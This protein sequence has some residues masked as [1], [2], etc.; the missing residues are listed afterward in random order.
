[1]LQLGLLIF[2]LGLA[3]N[4]EANLGLQPWGLF[5][6]GLIRFIP[7]TYG[8][9]TI[10]IG[11]VM[12][13]VSW[14]ARVPPGFGTVCNMVF[15]GLWLDLFIALLPTARGLIDGFLV[16]IVGL[17]T[18]AFASALYIKA[19]LGAGPRDSFMLAILRW[20]GWKVGV[21]RVAMDGTVFVIGALLDP[22]HVGIGTVIYAFGF[23]VV[24]NWTFK[25]LNVTAR[26]KSRPGVGDG[27]R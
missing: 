2:G 4:Y 21:A 5:Q 25:L 10:A 24:M 14:L 22:H 3:L 26:G 16:L 27:K 17:V 6:N 18:L 1:M 7:L 19:G 12:I 15:V 23:G 9:M 13:G 11:A 8:Q 20:T